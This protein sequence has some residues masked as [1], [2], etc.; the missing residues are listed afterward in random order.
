MRK[1]QE[2]AGSLHCSSQ[3][4]SRDLKAVVICSPGGLSTFFFPGY[5]KYH[6]NQWPRSKVGRGRED[7]RLLD[8]YAGQNL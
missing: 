6:M 3:E 2:V 4:A 1:E 8:F 5:F 7:S